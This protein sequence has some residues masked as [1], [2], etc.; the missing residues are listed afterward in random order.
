MS[1]VWSGRT[2]IVSYSNPALYTCL[3]FENTWR[4]GD[5]IDRPL[6]FAH[7]TTLKMMLNSFSGIINCSLWTENINSDENVVLYC[8]GANVGFWCAG[9]IFTA[10]VTHQE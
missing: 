10:A 9:V 5:K 6:D 4:H 2:N 7:S 3:D 1:N 8:P